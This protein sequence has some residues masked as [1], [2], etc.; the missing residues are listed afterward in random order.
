MIALQ[1]NERNQCDVRDRVVEDVRNTWRQFQRTSSSYSIA[2]ARV[3][4]AQRQVDSTLMLL[5]AGRAIVRDVLDAQAAL[6]SA[7]NDEAAAIV[8]YEVS[9]LNLAVNM[10]ILQVSE[11]GQLKENFDEYFRPQGQ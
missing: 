9:R 3:A 2:V 4:L 1:Q 10:D 5:Q 7:Q 11:T 6:L 8:D